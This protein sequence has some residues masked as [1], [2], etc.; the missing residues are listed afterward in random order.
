[1][2]KIF[3]A[4]TVAA[5]LVAA[6]L[7]LGNHF[8]RQANQ[9]GFVSGYRAGYAAAE[10]N[11]DPEN[12]YPACGV[13]IEVNHNAD[14]VTVQDA[15]GFTWTFYE[16]EDWMPGD[17]A[18]LTMYNYGTPTITDDEIIDVKYCGIIKWFAEIN[19]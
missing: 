18:A 11:P 19:Y 10:K 4:V 15:N 1:M 6:A 7:L 16:A 9:E 3:I 13:V 12:I 2:K 8:V 17:V 5:A 14:T